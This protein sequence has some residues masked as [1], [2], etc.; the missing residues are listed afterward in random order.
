ML[1]NYYQNMNKD[2]I[3]YYTIDNKY[4]EPITILSII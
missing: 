1:M 2:I 3:E 4:I